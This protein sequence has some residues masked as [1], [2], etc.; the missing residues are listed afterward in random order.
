MVSS[1]TQSGIDRMI[2]LQVEPPQHSVVK[3]S[4]DKIALLILGIGAVVLFV[5]YSQKNKSNK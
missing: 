4:Q 5:R 3:T 2:R 1:I